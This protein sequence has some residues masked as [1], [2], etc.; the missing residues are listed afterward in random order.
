MVRLSKR[1]AAGLVT[2]LALGA[3]GREAER[4]ARPDAQA[5]ASAQ[6]SAPDSASRFATRAS[7]SSRRADPQDA[8]PAFEDGKPSWATSRRYSAS[9]SEQRQ[10]ERNGAAFSAKS[11]DDYIAKAHAFVDSPPR[12]VQS[13][14]RANGDTLYYDPKSNV[15][16]V[17]DKQ[18][19]PR[20]MFKP[21]EGMAYWTQQKQSL[22]DRG[23]GRRSSRDR[24]SAADDANG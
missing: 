20:T 7:Y 17:V 13:A 8:A 9:D 5:Q 10:F 14:V 6:A 21:R 11:A 23:G 19:A 3:C 1:L 16:A 24:S 12:G 22:A 4:A 15:F 2:V 18:G